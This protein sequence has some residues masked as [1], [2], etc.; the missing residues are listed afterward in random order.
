MFKPFYYVR[1][2]PKDGD[3][4][5]GFL[6][7]EGMMRG[8]IAADLLRAS[9]RFKNVEMLSEYQLR[10]FEGV[11]ACITAEMQ[12]AGSWAASEQNAILQAIEAKLIQGSEKR[13]WND[14]DWIM[15]Y[16]MLGATT[17]EL[18]LACQDLIVNDP[19]KHR[20][21]REMGMYMPVHIRTRL[22]NGIVEPREALEKTV[23]KIRR[24]DTLMCKFQWTDETSKKLFYEIAVEEDFATSSLLAS[25][26]SLWS[27]S[28]P[29]QKKAAQ[30]AARERKVKILPKDAKV[31][32]KVL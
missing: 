17:E 23:R 9:S 30:L 16:R 19:N 29:E 28:T 32:E 5:I 10:R 13:D 8:R 2:L 26:I 21:D 24:A 27:I 31:K 18:L 6:K 11:D 20:T 22:R 25:M 12:V 14:Q 4:W 1:V 15:A 7:L 3:E